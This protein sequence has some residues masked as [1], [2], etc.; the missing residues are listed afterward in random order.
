MNVL[1][2]GAA[3]SIGS[4]FVDL[5]AWFRENPERLSPGGSG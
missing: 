1:V 4:H 5:L 2:T 3:G